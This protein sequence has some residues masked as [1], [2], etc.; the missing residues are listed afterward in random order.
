MPASQLHFT[1][2]ARLS[3]M[4]L[5]TNLLSQVAAVVTAVII[6]KLVHTDKLRVEACEKRS[7]NNTIGTRMTLK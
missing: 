2:W 6:S 5:D 7:E 1:T 4:I 3:Y